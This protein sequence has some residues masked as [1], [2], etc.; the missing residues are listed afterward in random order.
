MVRTRVCVQRSSGVQGARLVC[1]T[2]ARSW[3]NASGEGRKAQTRKDT[4]MKT[5]TKFATLAFGA[6][7]LIALMGSPASAQSVGG[8]KCSTIREIDKKT[9]CLTRAT[10]QIQDKEGDQGPRDQRALG[11]SRAPSGRP[12]WQDPARIVIRQDGAVIV[13]HDGPNRGL[14]SITKDGFTRNYTIPG[15][16]GSGGKR[17]AN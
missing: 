11:N 10:D 7:S 13:F 4:S 3:G 12:R 8:S 5:S 15:R 2:L 17:W 14:G 6:A 1:H 16:G 9:Q